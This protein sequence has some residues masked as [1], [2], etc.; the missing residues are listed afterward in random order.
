MKRSFFQGAVVSILLYGCTTLTLTKWMEKKVDSNY[1]CMLQA[2]MNKSRRQHS[3]NQQLYSHLPP[4]TQTIQARW[5]RQKQGRTHKWCTP[6][7]PTTWPSKSRATSSNLYTAALW[8]RGV[9][10]GTCRRQWTIWRD[11]ERGSGISMLM[12]R[13]DDDDDIH[14]VRKGPDA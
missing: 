4:I 3:R 10:L 8:I 6:M 1:T 11:G 14:Y 13:Q 12:A 5:T 9:V 2:I 7:D